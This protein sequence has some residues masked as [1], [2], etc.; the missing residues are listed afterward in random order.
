MCKYI[1][2]QF[3]S[4]LFLH[5]IFLF[6]ILIFCILLHLDGVGHRLQD[7]VFQLRNE[8]I[9]WK[10]VRIHPI[11]TPIRD[12]G[13]FW[14]P[15]RLRRHCRLPVPR[16]WRSIRQCCRSPLLQLGCR[17]RVGGEHEANLV[18]RWIRSRRILSLCLRR[19]RA[20]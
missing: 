13:R 11:V 15:G 3:Q 2:A 16:R 5:G 20:G 7:A 10:E 14:T 17:Q 19:I 9:R 8:V 6:V 4:K 12:A 1:V 18:A